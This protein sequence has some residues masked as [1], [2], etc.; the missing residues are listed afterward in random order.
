MYRDMSDS[1]TN[2]LAYDFTDGV[3]DVYL[4]LL[5]ANAHR[6][7]HTNAYNLAY[8]FTNANILSVRRS[9]A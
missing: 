7:R 5:I 4:V 6:L 2:R 3:A 8:R 9:T 1:N